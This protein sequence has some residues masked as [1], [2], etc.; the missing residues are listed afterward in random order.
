MHFSVLLCNLRQEQK[1]L[2]LTIKF[3]KMKRF[4]LAL[5]TIISMAI[6]CKST[7]SMAVI[8]PKQGT[9][10][11]PEKGEFRIWKD[12][13]HPSFTVTLSNPSATQS[14]EVYTVK[15]SGSEKWISPSLQAGKTL[16]ITVPANGHLFFKNFNPNILKID[17]KVKE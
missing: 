17:Y 14:C 6:S 9:I 3:K 12:I 1:Y 11:L 2:S 15:S 4:T 8:Q 7:G 13:A 10:E 5:L 16:T